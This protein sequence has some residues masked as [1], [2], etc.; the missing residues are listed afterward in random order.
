MVLGSDKSCEGVATS[1]RFPS[2][3]GSFSLGNYG[4]EAGPPDA[5][6]DSPIKTS[7]VSER[8]KA[9][10]ALAAKKQQSD[11][12]SDGG[13]S[14]FRDRH[15]EKSPTDSSKSPIENRMSPNEKI[16]PTIQKM[17]GSSE[18]ES[19][20]SPFEVLGDL[21]QVNEF[22][23]TEEWM[24]AHLPPVPDLTS[25]DLTEGTNSVESKDKGT[26]VVIPTSF[27]SVPDAFM[28]SPVEAPSVKDDFDNAKKQPNVEEEF[29]FNF[30]PTAYMWD[31]Q[32]KSDDQPPSNLDSV[33]ASPPAGFGTPCPEAKQNASDEEKASLT[34]DPEPPEPSEADSSGESDDTVIEDEAG[35]PASAPHPSFEPQLSKDPTA[36]PASSNV[37][38]AEKETPPPKS[39]RKLMQVPTINVI[40]TDEPNYSEEEMEMEPEEE[41]VDYEI[42][43]PPAS[44]SPETSHSQPEDTKTELPKTRPLETEFME[45]YSPPS[46]PVDSDAEY[47]PKRNIIATSPE[48]DN[49]ESAAKSETLPKPSAPKDTASGISQAQADESQIPPSKMNEE[50]SQF[51]LTNA[52]VDFPDNDDEWSDEAQEHTLPKLYE[53]GNMPTKETF[54]ETVPLSKTTFMQDDIYD[55]QS[56][57]YDYDASSPLY[58][59]DHKELSNAKERFLSDPSP[60][61]PDTPNACSAQTDV[62]EDRRSLGDIASLK[63]EAS[64]EQ[65]DQPSLQEYPPNPYSSFQ[66]EAQRSFS[67]QE[68]GQ[69][70]SNDV[71]AHGAQNESSISEPTDSFVEF[72]RECLK[73]RQDEEYPDSVHQGVHGKSELNKTSLHPSQ[74]P[75]TVV[76]DLE[77][78]QLTISALKELCSSQ[79]EEAV[80]THTKASARDQTDLSAASVQ[81]SSLASVTNP[82]C[83]QHVRA[84]DSKYSKEVEAIDELVAE[85]YHLAEHVLT[86]ILTH[87]SGNISFFWA[88][89]LLTSRTLLSWSNL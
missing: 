73:S 51:T 14:L 58:D 76:L 85:A 86:A 62:T 82:P 33:I 3:P 46:S 9:L 37:P 28:D 63:D 4:G 81:Q 43:N 24:K 34:R 87:L 26:R 89:S 83:S 66:S 59:I 57:D 47:S 48:I 1:L 42:E 31:Q 5:P 2:K 27:T 13:F 36:T 8:I 7:P 56:F 64:P 35:A 6:P 23:E 11:F 29:D 70:M 21:R 19:P 25:V 67:E 40:E 68:S 20:G 39:E 38:P 88:A 32:D 50:P 78:E 72:M 61:D 30:L 15:H 52:E 12:R 71:V 80:K 75:P 16:T 41:D 74:L 60:T 53:K 10:E 65:A 44:E 79:E 69:K 55:R 22:E 45:G 18:Q 17:G 49:R 84:Y 77:Q 54:I